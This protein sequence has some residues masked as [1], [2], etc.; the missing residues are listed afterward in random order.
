MLTK[1]T[2]TWAPEVRQRQIDRTPLGRLATPEDIGRSILAVATDLPATT[3]A[4]V[5]VDGGRQL[6]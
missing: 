5:P 4:V 2:S 1:F 6:G 3:G